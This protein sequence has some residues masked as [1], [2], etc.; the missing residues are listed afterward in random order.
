MKVKTGAGCEAGGGG[1]GEGERV[2]GAPPTATDEHRTVMAPQS[3]QA[4][5]QRHLVFCLSTCGIRGT[6]PSR[7]LPRQAR[8]DPAGVLA[9]HLLGHQAAAVGVACGAATRLHRVRLVEAIDVVHEA[10]RGV[11]EVV[12]AVGGAFP[13]V[14]G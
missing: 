4:S 1:G 14:G 6:G 11:D 8:P 12:A 10:G 13:R 7:L 9:Q 2:R 3:S 5:T